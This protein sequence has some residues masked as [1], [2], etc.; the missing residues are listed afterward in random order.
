M[1]NNED[2]LK[3]YS[4]YIHYNVYDSTWYAIH[5]DYTI[6]YLQDKKLIPTN[7]IFSNKDIQQLIEEVKTNG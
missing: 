7:K 6:F 5:R 3:L 4:Y 2:T 1:T